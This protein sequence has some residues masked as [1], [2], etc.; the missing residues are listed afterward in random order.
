MVT[1]IRNNVIVKPFP[2]DRTTE[3]GLIV[4][5]SA[6]KV[7]N[8]VKV[9]AVGKGT[10]TRPMTLFEGQTAFRVKDWGVEILIDGELHFIMEQS[11]IIATA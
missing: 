6:Q 8:K 1:P 4:P 11:A 3:G 9:V 7:S 2:P 10:K 5:E